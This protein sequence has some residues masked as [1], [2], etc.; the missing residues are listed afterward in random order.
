MQQQQS[1]FDRLREA[2]LIVPDYKFS[3]QDLRAIESLSEEEVTTIMRA[4]KKLAPEFPKVPGTVRGII[5]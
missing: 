3:D 1:N 5:L 4:V 2:G